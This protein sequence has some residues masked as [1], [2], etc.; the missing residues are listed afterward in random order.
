M[1]KEL[2]MK[3]YEA[4]QQSLLEVAD[5]LTNALAMVGVLEAEKRQWETEKIRQQ[6]IIVTQLGRSDSIVGQLQ[7]EIRSVK[8]KI[9]EGVVYATVGERIDKNKFLEYIRDIY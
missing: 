3:R 2:S 6:E 9:K 5:K 4:S 8:R 1:V 7:D